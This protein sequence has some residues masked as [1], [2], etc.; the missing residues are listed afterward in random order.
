MDFC[1]AV[2]DSQDEGLLPDPCAGMISGT[3]S[4]PR[5]TSWKTAEDSR[6]TLGHNQFGF[7]PGIDDLQRQWTAIVAVKLI[8]HLFTRAS[9]S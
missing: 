9:D 5:A 2:K 8:S 3:G 4:E 1:G 6:S 7:R